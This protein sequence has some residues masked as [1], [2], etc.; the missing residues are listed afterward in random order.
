MTMGFGRKLGAYSIFASLWFGSVA[1]MPANTFG[2]EVPVAAKDTKADKKDKKQKKEAK[3]TPTPSGPAALSAKDDPNQIGKRKINGGSDKFFGWLGGSQEKEI[4]IGRQL[5]LQVEQQSKLVEDPLVT[6]YVNRVG[7]NIV[8]H[9]DAKL[10][11]TIKVIDSDEVNAFA[12]PGGFFYVNRGLILAADNEAEL[13][14]VMA[15]EIAH[16]CAR[17]AMENQGKG[18]FINYAAI[19]GIIFGGPIVSGILQNGGGILAGLASLKFSRGAETEADNLGVQYL[20]ASGYDPMGMSTMFEKLASQNKKKPGAIQKLFSTHPPS[21]QRQDESVRIVS[22]FPE[23]EEYVITTS[24]FQRVKAHLLRL[25]NAKASISSDYDEAGDAKPTLKKR[26]PDAATDPSLDT[27]DGT[28]TSN[29]GPPKLKKRTEPT[30]PQPSP[31]PSP[32]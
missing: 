28:S 17:H 27:G 9:S 2:Q 4:A 13:A 6:E 3:A 32:Q 23:K 10:P 21:A 20:Y 30:D 19:A 8:L 22:R 1:I 12:L 11:F 7:Q 18:T 29:D 24:E 5:A 26:Q 25:T 16:V 15:H 14:G 31:S